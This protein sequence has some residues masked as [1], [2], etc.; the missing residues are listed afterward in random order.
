M[1]S[2]A[3]GPPASAASASLPPGRRRLPGRSDRGP[4]DVAIAVNSR[5]D[6]QPQRKDVGRMDPDRGAKGDQC[7]QPVG[8]SL[9]P[10][11]ASLV[12]ARGCRPARPRA[13]PSP[14]RNKGPGPSPESSGWRPRQID[15]RRSRS[16]APPT[17]PSTPGRF[18][19]RKR[20][21]RAKNS[22]PTRPRRWPAPP[23]AAPR[24][25][26]RTPGATRPPATAGTD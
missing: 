11:S 17:R 8:R 1:P 6:Q 19:D 4:P 3:S 9:A 10:R 13:R 20:G 15:C 23:A 14:A 2:V 7:R 24:P 16:A 12:V 18:G 21:G 25:T 5:H 22:P 26:G